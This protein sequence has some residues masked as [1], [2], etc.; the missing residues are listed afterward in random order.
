M[1]GKENEEFIYLDFAQRLKNIFDN[2]I[3][4]FDGLWHDLKENIL[5]GKWITNFQK[6]YLSI[7]SH[8]V[9]IILC[10]DTIHRTMHDPENQ[11]GD[12]QA[13]KF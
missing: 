3:K 9:S 7:K 6:Y 11:S 4:N 5:V 13:K 2:L 8:A 1:K 10:Y 12:G